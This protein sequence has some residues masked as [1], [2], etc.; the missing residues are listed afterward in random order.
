MK[1]LSRYTHERSPKIEEKTRILRPH[2]MASDPAATSPAATPV[3]YV[4]AAHVLLWV[5]RG[6]NERHLPSLLP[7]TLFHQTCHSCLLPHVCA[8]S[9][10]YNGLDTNAKDQLT[11]AARA[12]GPTLQL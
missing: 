2:T 10:Q 12:K 7:S 5:T 8:R 3:R 6:A 4:D 9:L 11:K 1:R